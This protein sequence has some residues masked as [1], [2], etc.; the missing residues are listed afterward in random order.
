MLLQVTRES[1]D[2]DQGRRR[3]ALAVVYGGSA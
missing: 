3:L 1:E 2:G